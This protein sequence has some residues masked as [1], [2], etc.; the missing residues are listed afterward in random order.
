VPRRFG[1]A[2]HPHR[3]DRFPHR[4]DFPVGGSHN[5]L[6]LRHI[7]GP[8]FSHRGSRPTRPNGKM[9]RTV[10]TFLDRM[11]KYWITKIY[12]TNLSTERSTSSHPM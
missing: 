6:E 2:P 11:V 1:Y 12:L 5:H 4:H 9:Q 7:D 3:G 10:K 8:R